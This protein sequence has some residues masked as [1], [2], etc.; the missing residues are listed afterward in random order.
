MNTNS[1]YSSDEDLFSY[2]AFFPFFNVYG[3]SF[4]AYSSSETFLKL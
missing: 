2:F 4:I 3:L 1:L